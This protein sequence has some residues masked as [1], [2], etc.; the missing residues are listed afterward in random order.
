MSALVL[1]LKETPPQRCDLSPLRPDR[2]AGADAGIERIEINTTRE[3]LRVGDL[4]TI[5]PG[6]IAEIHID[7]GSERFDYV[8]ARMTG[9]TI[10]VSGDLGQ[11]A[12]RRMRHGTIV[13]SGNVG[14]LAGSGMS[15]G[16]LQIGGS[17][18]DLVGGPLPGEATGM[19]GGVVHIAGNVGARAGDRMRRGLI[20]IGGDAGDYLASRM[21]AGTV[22]CFGKAGILPGYL[23]K[24]GTAVIAG[25]AASLAPTFIDT[26]AHELVAVRLMARWLVEE[27]IERGADLSARLRRLAGDTAVHG[28]GELFLP[29]DEKVQT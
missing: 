10:R 26:G 7:G 14:R 28:K 19:T 8:G 27:G 13:V 6:D 2:L 4:F 1:R 5:A 12:G 20:A 15:G 11:Q 21:I 9:G 17:A 24:R 18:S 23:M 22:V 25:G 3:P 16:R 29:P